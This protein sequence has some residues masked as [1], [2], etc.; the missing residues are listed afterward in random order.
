MHRFVEIDLISDHN[1]D[2]I[3]VAT[4]SVNVLAAMANLFIDHH[5]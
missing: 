2:E 4:T 5:H 3:G 1:P